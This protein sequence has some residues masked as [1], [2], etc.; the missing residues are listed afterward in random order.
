MLVKLPTHES[1]LR[2]S[3]GRSQATVQAQ[4]PPLLMPG[5]G[6]AV[7]VVAELHRLLDLG[8]DLLEQEPGV[9]VGERVVLEA[10][11]RPPPSSNDARA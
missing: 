3:S 5:D 2:N 10:P 7:G 4:M 9:L 11:V 8:Q 1:T 6:A